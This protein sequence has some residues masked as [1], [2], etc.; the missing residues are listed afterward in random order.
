ME[1]WRESGRGS[2][3]RN[4]SVHQP[5]CQYGNMASLQK[6]YRVL[7]LEHE[8]GDIGMCCRRT[9]CHTQILG[10]KHSPCRMDHLPCLHLFDKSFRLQHWVLIITTSTVSII[11]T[12]I[13]I[14]FRPAYDPDLKISSIWSTRD[15]IVKR[16]N[17][18]GNSN[19]STPFESHQ[20]V[21]S[22]YSG[23]TNSERDLRVVLTWIAD[24]QIQYLTTSC[25]AGLYMRTLLL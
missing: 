4:S 23:R 20:V 3:C 11:I 18:I 10:A 1:A 15:A 6:T 5:Q 25:H 19:S 7:L 22:R 21:Y 16:Y 24:T 17:Q 8:T 2:I 12:P 13:W 14:N 9:W